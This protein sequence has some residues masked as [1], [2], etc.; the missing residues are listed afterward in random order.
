MA[1]DLLALICAG[2]V[3]VVGLP[4]RIS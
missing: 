4:C 3:E 1:G 2:L